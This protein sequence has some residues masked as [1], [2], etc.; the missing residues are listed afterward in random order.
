[1]SKRKTSAAAAAN[2]KRQKA[3]TAPSDE[4]ELHAELEA[5]IMRI[6]TKRGLSK[7]C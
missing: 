7:T 6:L 2:S 4:A 3:A 5:E 1:M